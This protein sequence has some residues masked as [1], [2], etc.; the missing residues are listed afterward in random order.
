MILMW[1]GMRHCHVAQQLLLGEPL[2]GN[3]AS[4]DRKNTEGAYLLI[5]TYMFSEAGQHYNNNN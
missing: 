2:Y 1:F 3:T 5:F 4:H